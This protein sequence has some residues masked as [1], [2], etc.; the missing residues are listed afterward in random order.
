MLAAMQMLM[1]EMVALGMMTVTLTAIMATPALW[2]VPYGLP[3]CL[4]TES[5][6]F[7]LNSLN[8]G[9]TE[10]KSEACEVC[11]HSPG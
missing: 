10:E 6:Q 7:R 11:S 4:S 8:T 3:L 9:V 2:G 1:T 5:Y